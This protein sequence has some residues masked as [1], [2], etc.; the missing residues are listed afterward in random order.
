MLNL[1]QEIV[2]WNN[3]FPY[4]RVYRQKHKIAFG[5][6]AHRSVNQIDVYR[7]AL[8]DRMFQDLFEEVAKDKE[9][10]ENYEKNGILREECV[11][12]QEDELY[13]IFESLDVNQLNTEVDEQ[14]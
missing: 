1:R 14:Q 12:A 8:E 10:A 6:E 7:D 2:E 4:D 11:K 5:S 13:D 3:K 9:M